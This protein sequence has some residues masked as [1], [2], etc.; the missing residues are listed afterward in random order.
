MRTLRRD[1]HSAI[2]QL[3]KYPAFTLSA[4]LTLALG[5]ATNTAIF[6]IVNGWLRPLPVASPEQLVVLAAQQKDDAVGVYYLSYPALVDFRKQTDVFSDVFADQIGFGGLSF[7]GKA[8]PFVFSYV[9]GNFLSGL[10]IKPAAGRLLLPQEGEHAGD[11]PVLVLSYAYW[12]KRFHGDPGIVGKQVRL[13]GQPAVIIGVAQKDFYGVHSGVELS[14]YA[15]LSMM[16][17]EANKAGLWTDRSQRI[18][19]TMARLKPGVTLRK[20][21]SSLD[22]VSNRMALE[23]PKTDDG[24]KVNAVPER[25]ARPVPRLASAIPLISGLFLVLAGLVLLL[26]CMNVANLLLVR[27]TARRQELSVRSALGATGRLLIQ[28]MLTESLM[29]SLLGATAGVAMGI[30]ATNAIGAINLGTKLP[31]RLDFGFDWRVFIYSLI[32]ALFTGFIVGAWPAIRASRSAARPVLQEG[33]RSGPAGGR[34]RIRSLLI[35]AQVAGSLMLLII[36]AR[37]VRSLGQAQHMALGFEPAHVINIMLDPHQVGYD[38]TRTTEFYRELENRV[39]ALPGV[40]SAS[41]SFSVPMGSYNDA[42]QIYIEDAPLAPGQHP[43]LVLFNR[44][45]ESYFTTMQTPV[46]RGRPFT[47]I[48]NESAPLVAVINQ[49]MALKYWPNADPLGKRFSIK[50]ASGPFIQIVGVAQDTKLFGFFSAPMP[51]FYVPFKQN[52]TATRILQTRTSVAPESLEPMLERQVQALDPEMPISDLQTMREA[53]AGGNGFLIFR[54]GAVLTAAMGLLGLV[55]ATV[56]I[57]GVVSFAAGQRTR[58]IGVRM[59]LGASRGNILNLVFSQGIRLVF[60]GIAIG[61]AAAFALTR[62]MTNLLVGVTATDLT[63]AVPITLLLMTIVLLACY[64][65]AR[66]AMGVDPIVALRRD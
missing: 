60:I 15:P 17:Q 55:I 50:S 36:A 32:A 47:E 33:G 23:Y 37:F 5:I 52:Y 43:P 56:G 49:G 16:L 9:T 34:Q 58:E 10:A 8:E 38:E 27:M 54:L 29:L 61:L 66:R 65:P 1:I 53:M 40:K 39:R 41:L 59:A 21:Q 26:A 18:L 4:A 51:Y 11:A 13:D 14:G 25:L 42:R 63:T 6:S 22:L 35:V 57:Y 12:Q 19:A 7:E 44:I 20:A 28:Q 2:R 30:W 3:L 48:D 62:A 46:L 24:I 64:V 31:I 45:D